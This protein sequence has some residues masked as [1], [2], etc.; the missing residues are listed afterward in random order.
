MAVFTAIVIVFF[1][2][3]CLKHYLASRNFPPGYLRFPLIGS[4]L[5]FRGNYGSTLL[6]ATVEDSKK[7]GS[8]DGKLMGFFLGPSAKYV[9]KVVI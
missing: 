3:L 1:S 5:S 7:W 9:L 6:E 8:K 2:L 4:V